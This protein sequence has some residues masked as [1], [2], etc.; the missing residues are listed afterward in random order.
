MLYEQMDEQAGG[1]M[2]TTYT[3]L[4]AIFCLLAVRASADD[5]ATPLGEECR[6][7]GAEVAL[8]SELGSAGFMQNLAGHPD[9]IKAVAGRLLTEAFSRDTDDA[10]AGCKPACQTAPVT[11]V[12]YRVAPTAFLADAEQNDVC[13]Q[14]ESTTSA[15]PLRFAPAPF[16]TVDEV[17]EW[18]MDFS[19]GRGDAGHELYERCSS[20]CSPRYTFLIAEQNTGF[21]VKA[22]VLC[23]L[24]RDKTRNQYRISTALRRSCGLN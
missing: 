21:S 5:L 13:R 14:F 20:N 15:K 9:S 24:A 4:A 19:Q 2:R 12:V 22:E 7:A 16:A 3:K 17:N 23:G 10:T 1:R 18:I 6:I 8:A 11:E